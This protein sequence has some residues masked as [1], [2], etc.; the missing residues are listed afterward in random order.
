MAETAERG[1][2]VAEQEQ[3]RAIEAEDTIDLEEEEE[4]P[5]W[6]D[7]VSKNLDRLLLGIVSLGTGPS[8]MHQLAQL[9]GDKAAE[10]QEAR[11]RL[12]SVLTGLQ[13][14]LEQMSSSLKTELQNSGQLEPAQQRELFAGLDDVLS[15]YGNLLASSG[16]T[17]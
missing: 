14:T 11:A 2:A 4:Q 9:G 13:K 1:Y 17:H 15:R 16:E 8:V 3:R 10:S 6:C 5:A 7:T 12:C